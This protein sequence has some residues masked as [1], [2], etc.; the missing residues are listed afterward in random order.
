MADVDPIPSN[1][2]RVTPYLSIDG[3]ADALA[4]YVDVLGA[5]ITT[6]MEAPNG[7][8]AHAEITLGDGLIMLA[9]TWPDMGNPSPT[10]LGGTP[11]TLM[12]YVADVDATFAKAL[13]AG[14]SETRPVEDQFYGDRSG[15]F[16]DPWGHVWNVSSHIEDVS[17]EEMAR[18]AAEAMPQ[19]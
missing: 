10:Q 19:D 17:D 2:P 3:A 13:A 4:F 1:V 7:K 11:V 9:D 6:R 16:T 14:A 12:V 8:V 18:R 15:Q 5:E